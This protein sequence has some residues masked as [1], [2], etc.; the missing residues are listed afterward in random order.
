MVL[1]VDGELLLTIVGV[2]R[3][4]NHHVM[5]IVRLDLLNRLL[6]QQCVVLVDPVDA[7][8]IAS[9]KEVHTS[10]SQAIHRVTII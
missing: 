1:Q 10:F 5:G 7:G 2:L 6:V 9:V 3:P 8:K 4:L